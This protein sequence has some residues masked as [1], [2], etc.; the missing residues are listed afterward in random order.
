VL[1]KSHLS[2][3]IPK[4]YSPSAISK[5]SRSNR[6]LFWCV[7]LPLN[8]LIIMSS[9]AGSRSVEHRSRARSV[10]Y[11]VEIPV[12][13]VIIF[14]LSSRLQGAHSPNYS[15]RVLRTQLS[16]EHIPAAGETALPQR[17]NC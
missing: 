9:P 5:A 7:Q 10:S 16:G 15:A 4:T 6:C 2:A 1:R 12:I 3:S 11:P 14:R 8:F 17:L 13:Q